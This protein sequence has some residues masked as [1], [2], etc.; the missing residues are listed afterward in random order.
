MN[1]WE[2]KTLAQLDATEWESLCDGCGRCCLIKLADD[3]S[4]RVEFTAVA[5]RLLDL[6]TCR[7]RRY[8]H[9]QRWV[10]DCVQLDAELVGR[11]NWLPTTCAYRLVHEGKPLFPWHPLVSGTRESVQQAGISVRGKVLSEQHVH[12]ESFADRVIHWVSAE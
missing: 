12:P 5:C 6:K 1:F 11:I 9:R 10:A 7:C 4:G 8:A 2:H 3:D